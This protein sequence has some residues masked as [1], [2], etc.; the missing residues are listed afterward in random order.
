[1][2]TS[3]LLKTI[4]DEKERMDKAMHQQNE[5]MPANHGRRGDT[6]L[7]RTRRFGHNH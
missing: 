4:S 1:M 2:K 3:S 5:A 7:H 6:P